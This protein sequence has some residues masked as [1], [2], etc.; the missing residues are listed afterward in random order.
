MIKSQCCALIWTRFKCPLCEDKLETKRGRRQWARKKER[1]ER[2]AWEEL[3]LLW[4]NTCRDTPDRLW[5]CG[6]AKKELANGWHHFNLFIDSAAAP[7]PFPENYYYLRQCVRCRLS[8]WYKDGAKL[9]AV[10][11]GEGLEHGART[12]PLR[13]RAD[14][15]FIS[16]CSFLLI[17]FSYGFNLVPTLCFI[18]SEGCPPLC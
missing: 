8:V 11:H 13:L 16:L 14:P 15:R 1:E 12:N 2:G 10:K 9:P 3:I 5:S 18:K 6:A 7:L 17:S 4:I